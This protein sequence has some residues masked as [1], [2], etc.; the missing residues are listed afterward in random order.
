MS[1]AKS[2]V[3]PRSPTIVKR[4]VRTVMRMVSWVVVAWLAFIIVRIVAQTLRT[5]PSFS[6]GG[7]LL[8]F[9]ISLPIGAVEVA[10]AATA[11]CAMLIV[12]YAYVVWPQPERRFWGEDLRWSRAALAALGLGA[13]AGLVYSL[14]APHAR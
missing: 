14:V 11:V 6:L 8:G 3:A 5:H 10:A 9:A 4:T 1:K 7:W 13:L 2:A 12:P